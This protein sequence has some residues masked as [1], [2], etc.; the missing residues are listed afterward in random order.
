MAAGNS[1]DAYYGHA[2]LV[3]RS[4]TAPLRLARPGLTAGPAWPTLVVTQ[5]DLGLLLAQFLGHTY[6]FHPEA[7]NPV[8][9]LRHL[10][11]LACR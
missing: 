10:V 7:E 3:P 5:K 4:G 2:F 8:Q 6:R 9:I 1:D 11:V